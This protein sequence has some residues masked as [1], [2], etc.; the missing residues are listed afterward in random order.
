MAPVRKKEI[1]LITWLPKDEVC[2]ALANLL[3]WTDVKL[4]R[5]HQPHANVF[6]ERDGAGK[7]GRPSTTLLRPLGGKGRPDA[8]V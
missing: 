7:I 5:R 4:Y 6:R 8:F 3:L 2:D 1:A